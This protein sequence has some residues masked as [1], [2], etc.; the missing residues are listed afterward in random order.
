MHGGVLAVA[1]LVGLQRG[2]QIAL[3]LAAQ[4][5]YGIGWIDVLLVRNAVAAKAGVG[6]DAASFRV[7]F[8][9]CK[10]SLAEHDDEENCQ[11]VLGHESSPVIGVSDGLHYNCLAGQH[12]P[13]KAVFGDTVNQTTQTAAPRAPEGCTCTIFLADCSPGRP[14]RS[15][16]CPQARCAAPGAVQMR[17]ACIGREYRP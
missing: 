17:A 1:A 15:G 3:C 5:G 10:Y 12:I 2:D 4:L 16:P 6:D 11:Y 9:L 8:I 13:G 14:L 7:A